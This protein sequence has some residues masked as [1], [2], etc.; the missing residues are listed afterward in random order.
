[1]T[2]PPLYVPS[3]KKIACLLDKATATVFDRE[4]A[5]LSFVR[6]LIADWLKSRQ[7][8]GQ[9][10]RE[11]RNYDGQ[12]HSG[13]RESSTNRKK[14]GEKE[15]ERERRGGGEV[16]RA[17]GITST[18]RC[19]SNSATKYPHCL[20]C[21]P[22]Y[23]NGVKFNKAAWVAPATRYR[24]CY[25]RAYPPFSFSLLDL[26]PLERPFKAPRNS[27]WAPAD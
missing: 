27:I 3:G 7:K 2:K 20:I 21:S 12:R 11:S 6:A 5:T 14:M 8:R 19:N 17:S 13:V 15:R 25:V 22:I 16:Y 4:I 9:R 23:S 10:R 1:M 18:T 24:I 26:F